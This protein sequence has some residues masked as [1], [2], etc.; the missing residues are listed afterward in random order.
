MWLVQRSSDSHVT[1]EFGYSINRDYNESEWQIHELPVDPSID[2][3]LR[4]RLEFIGPMIYNGS[5][6]SCID[7]VTVTSLV[8]HSIVLLVNTSIVTCG[9]IGRDNFYIAA[10]VDFRSG[11]FGRIQVLKWRCE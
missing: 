3:K 4:C 10:T 2:A 11:V 1:V 8:M 5:A 9:T 6:G 7:N